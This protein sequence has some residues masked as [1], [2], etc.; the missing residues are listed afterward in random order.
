MLQPIDK[1]QLQTISTCNANCVFCP[2]IESWHKANPGRMEHKLF[3]KILNEMEEY[4]NFN[5]FCPYFMN[6]PLTDNRV[7]TWMNEFYDKYP[8]KKIELSVN[9]K[10]LIKKNRKKLI[11]T[12][13]DKDHTLLVSFHGM[14]E[15]SLR[16]IMDLDFSTCLNNLVSLVKESKGALNTVIRGAGM[17]INN[18]IFYFTGG[19]YINFWKD[20]FQD[21]DIALDAVG[22]QT[23]GFHDRAGQINRDERDANKNR[24]GIIREIGPDKPFDCVRFDKVLHVLYNGDIASCCMDYKKEIPN[25]GNLN[26]MTIT[27]YFESDE[28]K[29]WV[30]MGTG[31]TESPKDFL[32]ARCVSPGG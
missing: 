11:S 7:F 20:V 4:D 24:L 16:Y 25:L 27:E 32:C 28:Y 1:L 19:H 21:N 2:Y 29:Q 14:N 23:F 31:K 10:L 13:K 9:P 26:D 18:K 3:V 12:F 6:E 22:V 17:S 30:S 8:D 5:T 15:T